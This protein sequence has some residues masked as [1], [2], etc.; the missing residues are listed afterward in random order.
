MYQYKVTFLTLGGF[1]HHCQYIA[2]D[3]AMIDRAIDPILRNSDITIA[4][5][6]KVGEITEAVPIE[7]EE[8]R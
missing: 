4:K 6:E 1:E 2:T 7:N 3:D 8:T 5:V